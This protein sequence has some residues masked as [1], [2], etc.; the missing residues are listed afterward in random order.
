MFII[1]LKDIAYNSGLDGRSMNNTIAGVDQSM[2]CVWSYIVSM[3]G[4]PDPAPVYR[5]AGVVGAPFS[6]TPRNA[7]LVLSKTYQ[8]HLKM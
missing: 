1:N 8:N 7:L 3:A 6:Y 2:A 5:C 4:A